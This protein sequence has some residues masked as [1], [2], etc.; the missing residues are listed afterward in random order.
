MKQ[1]YNIWKYDDGHGQGMED[2]RLP[3]EGL[4]YNSKLSLI[5][6]NRKEEDILDDR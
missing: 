2:W 6:M 1:F 4:N 3:K 5:I